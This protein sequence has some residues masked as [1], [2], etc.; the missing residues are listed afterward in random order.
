MQDYRSFGAMPLFTLDAC[1]MFADRLVHDVTISVVG[2]DNISKIKEKA[3][4]KILRQSIFSKLYEKRNEL[5]S[6]RNTQQALLNKIS[7]SLET[8]LRNK[9]WLRVKNKIRFGNIHTHV[10]VK[11][12][13][14]IANSMGFFQNLILKEIQDFIN[15]QKLLATPTPAP[16]HSPTQPISNPSLPYGFSLP[17]QAPTSTTY[18]PYSSYNSYPA[19]IPTPAPTLALTQLLNPLHPYGLSMPVQTPTSTKHNPYSLNISYPAAIPTPVP[20]L[21]LTQP[22]NPSHPYGLSMP[23]QTSTQSTYNPR[24]SAYSHFGLFSQQQAVTASISNPPQLKGR[25]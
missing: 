22:L 15:A 1:N 21:A 17:T 6:Y 23:V 19:A 24:N 25:R 18:N 2:K 13:K 11:K 10:K 5:D 4:E 14:H 12:I 3:L 8:E 9:K 20:T 16:N 7:Y